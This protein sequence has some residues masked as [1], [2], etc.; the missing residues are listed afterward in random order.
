MAKIKDTEGKF[1][2]DPS[3][4]ITKI[5][6]LTKTSSENDTSL[7]DIQLDLGEPL[8]NTNDKTLIIGTGA[9]KAANDASTIVLGNGRNVITDNGNNTITLK[10]FDGNT[11]TARSSQNISIT[12][13]AL[14]AKDGNVEIDATHSLE[15]GVV[16]NAGAT[17]TLSGTNMN[18]STPKLITKNIISE[19]STG[20]SNS[21][22]SANGVYL[23]H[24]EN[25]AIQSSHRIY[26]DNGIKVTSDSDGNIT[27]KQADITIEANS[28]DDDVVVLEGTSGTNSVTYN[29]THAKKGPEEG[30]TSS[31]TITEV[32]GSGGTGTIYI[33]QLT[34]DPYGHV[35]AASDEGVTITLPGI[36]DA[37]DAN[38][39]NTAASSKA[40]KK[41]NDEKAPNNHAST[42]S[43]YGVATGEKYGHVQI[44]TNIT[45]DNGIISVSTAGDNTLGLVKSGGDV[46][47]SDGVITVNNNSHNH[48]IDDVTDLR[49]SLNTKLDKIGTDNIIIKDVGETFKYLEFRYSNDDDATPASI[50]SWRL[51]NDGTGSENTNYFRIQSTKSSGT[52]G[53]TDALRIGMDDHDLTVDGSIIANTFNGAT[54]SETQF[55]G[56]TITAAGAI[57]AGKPGSYQQVT[58]GSFNAMSDARLKENLR[59]LT[60]EK[61]ILDLPTYKFDFINGAKNQIG[62]KAQDLQEICPEIVNEADDGYLSIQESKIVYLLL[63]EVKKLRKEIDDL[64][65][66]NL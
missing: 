21:A 60:P 43:T 13:G 47:I 42:N 16:A 41:L 33:P 14:S 62:C 12:G 51:G 48:I 15:I 25:D 44:G 37:L 30:Y 4:A 8:V 58:A 59:P 2:L 36:S 22:N 19:T 10:H 7:A 6:L 66:L 45:V 35:T 24:L 23:N 39:S 27:I 38:D 29:V 9:N 40:V 18:S 5:Q 53:F 65:G 28:E 31:N 1:T 55:N 17:F 63:E 52:S 11:S 50:A 54:I 61:S 49:T 34:V 32:A 57:T 20:T 26:G 3:E 56:A 64:K 46:T